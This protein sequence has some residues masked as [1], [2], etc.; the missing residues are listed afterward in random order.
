MTAAPATVAPARIEEEPSAETRPRLKAR[1][2]SRRRWV[3][4][5]AIFLAFF[6]LYFGIGHHVVVD[7]HLVNFD[8]LSRLSHA[9]FV[10]WND[11]PKL[12]AVGFIWPPVQTLVFLPFAVIKPLATSLAALP[13]MSAT[14]M[15]ATMV[16]LNRSLEISD[17]RWFARLPLLVAFGIN[18]MIVY[19][20]ANGMA[21]AVYLCFL[22]IG[23]YFLVRWN[24]TRRTHFL[25]FVG[26]AMA[27]ALLARYE[28]FPFV[29][30]VAAGIAAITMAGREKVYRPQELEGS[31]LL[32]LAPIAYAGS[33]WIFFNWL[34]IGDPIS[35]LGIGPTTADVGTSQQDI[36]G[37]A[38]RDLGA[39]EIARFL[40]TLNLG[41]FPLAVLVMPALLTTAVAKRDLM[42]LVLAALVITNAAVTA[43]LF[44]R[45]NDPNL[46]QLR[47]NMRAIP[48]ALIALGW[49]YYVW[50]PRGV[51]IG[52][53]VAGLLVLL[54]S[55]PSTWRVMETYSYQYEENLFL[56]AIETGQDQE[57]NI[58]IGGYPIGIK[59][60]QTMAD[61]I[62]QDVPPGEVILTDD[63]Q[64][65]GIMLLSGR[66][67]DFF[68]RI[69]RGDERWNEALND[70]FGEV[71]YFLVTTN[72]RCR[73]PCEDKV[74]ARYPGI[75]R[76][77]EPGM[78]VVLETP[79][80][81][82]VAV[83]PV[84]PRDRDRSEP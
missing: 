27:L 53:W 34:I 43:L 74:R 2:R 22:V 29:L 66:P 61:Y 26:V 7:L 5:L 80:Y 54:V 72:E 30:V 24:L 68:D 38:A 60:E 8:A 51:R 73:P 62:D 6:G 17:M 81:V 48:L 25:A 33:A 77:R 21:E 4:S 70:P 14:F 16:V 71:D 78:E 55:L 52:I 44:I 64:T 9:Y 56:R 49:L 82:L 42:S 79:Q 75:L 83:D 45:T 67:G 41:L 23:I 39:S 69:D 1:P 47:Y 35:F 18:P 37:L 28:I 36:A 65:L 3:E 84:A 63:A 10:W 20:G 58:A 57:G 15:A 76:D 12:A 50:K 31:L 32:F 13:A 19:Y 40:L 11:P 59:D 46:V